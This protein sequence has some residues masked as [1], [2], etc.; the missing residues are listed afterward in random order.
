MTEIKITENKNASTPDVERT[1]SAQVYIPDVDIIENKEQ[2]LVLADMPGVHEKSVQVTL[3]N[4]VLT[5]EGTAEATLPDGYRPTHREYETG[6][7]SR[8]FTITE[9]VDPKGIQARLRN[10]VLRVILPKSEAVKP[11]RIA[12]QTE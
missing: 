11:R 7:Y 4:D 6:S 8:S 12:V 10:G 3:E 1:R 9:T 5:I 2:I